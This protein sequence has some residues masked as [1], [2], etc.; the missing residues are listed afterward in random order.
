MDWVLY[1]W[2][3]DPRL[4]GLDMVGFFPSHCL[5]FVC[6]SVSIMV[7]DNVLNNMLNDCFFLSYWLMVKINLHRILV[8]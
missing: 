7:I 1:L 6:S 2:Y 3:V 4:L 5:V 8:W